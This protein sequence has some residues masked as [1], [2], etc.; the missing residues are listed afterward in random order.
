[1]E[2]TGSGL[3]P[4][5]LNSHK[6]TS[7]HIMKRQIF[8]NK[9]MDK[10]S[11]S[12]V[13][14]AWMEPRFHVSHN[15]QHPCGAASSVPLLCQTTTKSPPMSPDVTVPGSRKEMQLIHPKFSRLNHAILID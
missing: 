10:R 13:E 2:T 14:R 1:M 9:T 11:L 7:E 8:R 5:A 15:L 6:R 12:C 3:R 4:L